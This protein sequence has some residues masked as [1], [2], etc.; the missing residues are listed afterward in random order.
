MTRSLN[1]KREKPAEYLLLL[2][3]QTNEAAVKLYQRFDF[4][5]IPVVTRGPAG[6]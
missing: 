3:D 2:V 1:R 4:E 6:C 5:L